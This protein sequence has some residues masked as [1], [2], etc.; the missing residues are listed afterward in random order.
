MRLSFMKSLA[1]VLLLVLPVL[2]QAYG[3]RDWLSANQHFSREFQHQRN[4]RGL[5]YMEG[6]RRSTVRNESDRI[7]W[8]NEGNLRNNNSNSLHHWRREERKRKASDPYAD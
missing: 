5:N 3:T 6:A 1:G 8:M 7:R 2:A 4:I